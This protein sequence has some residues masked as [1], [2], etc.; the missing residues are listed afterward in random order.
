MKFKKVWSK[1][2]AVCTI[3]FHTVQWTEGWF[4]SM[5]MRVPLEHSPVKAEHF[6]TKTSLRPHPRP[7]SFPDDQQY[8]FCYW[9]FVLKSSL[10]RAKYL[11]DCSWEVLW[12]KKFLKACEHHIYVRDYPIWRWVV[13]KMTIQ[14]SSLLLQ[15]F[16]SLARYVLS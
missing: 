8:D 12:L 3:A 16:F 15:A 14:R 5:H 13:W 10:P 11:S 1:G 2:S 4:W 7:V 6:V 9:H